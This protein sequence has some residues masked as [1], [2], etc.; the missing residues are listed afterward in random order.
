MWLLPVAVLVDMQ[1]A[2]YYKHD[3]CIHYHK[4]HNVHITPHDPLCKNKLDVLYF[5]YAIFYVAWVNEIE[6]F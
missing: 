4:S 2:K 6:P 3:H 1:V 5:V